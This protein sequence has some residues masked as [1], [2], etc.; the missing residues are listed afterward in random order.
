MNIKKLIIYLFFIGLISGLIIF[1][2]SF[3]NP[4]NWFYKS[5]SFDGVPFEKNL[6]LENSSFSEDGLKGL[7]DFLKTEAGTTSMLVIEN[8]KAVFEYGDVA[9]ISIIASIRKSILAMLYGKYVDKNLIDLQ[10]KIGKI[11]IDEDDG[12]LPIEKQATVF[13]LLT[14]RS[15]VFHI[16]SNGGYDLKNIKERGSKEPGSYFVYNNW[17]FNAAGFVLETK[18]GKSVYEELENQ[19]VIPLGF[20]DWNIKNQKRKVNEDKS[21]YSAYHMH[22]STRDVAKIGQLMLQKGNWNGDQLIPTEWIH[23]ITTPVTPMDTISK[24]DELEKDHP[25]QFS[26]G[27]LWWVFEKFNDNPDFKGAYTASGS[28]GQYITVIPKRNV[29]ISH[30]SNMDIQSMAG[31]S[32]RRRTP[33]WKYWM[34]LEKL[35]DRK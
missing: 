23:K 27:M 19:L 21:R 26:Y 33:S 9:E 25:I 22:L 11:G 15:G 16:P 3:T 28:G 12:L 14:S 17:D 35:M 1:A 34:I 2:I 30:K 6:S 8:G 7:E 5:P 13:D 20:Q 32:D 4:K 29:V 31:I 18:T 24:R 10:E